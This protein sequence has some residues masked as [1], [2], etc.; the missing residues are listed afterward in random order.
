M[1]GKNAR[2]I[3]P[4]SAGLRNLDLPRPIFDEAALARADET[5]EAL[6]GSMEQWLVADVDR[7]QQARADAASAHWDNASL[8][9]M[10]S[11]AHDLKGM[12]GTY[13]FPIITQIAASLCRLIETDSGKAIAQR[14]PTLVC[15]HVDAL[16]AAA[17]DKI[18][19]AT[20]PV[21]RALLQALE[22]HVERLGVAPR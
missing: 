9:A 13:G 17:R 15:A 8:E 22:T 18:K 5:L 1:S 20:H 7:L 14:D 3:D 21:G 11:S 10:F 6:S 4:R 2:L 19:D 16:R 12:G